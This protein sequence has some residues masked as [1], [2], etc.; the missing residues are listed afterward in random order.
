MHS[1]HLI[2]FLSAYFE[3]HRISVK[4]SLISHLIPGCLSLLKPFLPIEQMVVALTDL[5]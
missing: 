2:L 1:K 4:D 3:K 5:M